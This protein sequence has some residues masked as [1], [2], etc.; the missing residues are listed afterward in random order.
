MRQIRVL[1]IDSRIARM[2]AMIPMMSLAAVPLFIL[3]FSMLVQ[4]ALR[5]RYA[6]VATFAIAPAAAMLASTL[7]PR[8]LVGVAVP[9]VIMTFMQIFGTARMHDQVQ[10]ITAGEALLAR[11]DAPNVPIIFADRGDAIELADLAP[12]LVSR[13]VIVDERRTPAVQLSD[14]RRYDLEMMK[15]ASA[16]YPTPPLITPHD[17][18]NFDRV[19]I[20]ADNDDLSR[21]LLEIPMRHVHDNLFQPIQ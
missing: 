15:K 18:L 6:I 4:S 13:I 5:P 21:L 9:L 7:R 1:P 12:D 8:M 11:R 17:L 3:L 19:R 10:R 20:V 2:R 16:F 14:H